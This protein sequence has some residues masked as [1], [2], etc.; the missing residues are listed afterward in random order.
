MGH[1]SYCESCHNDLL[2]EVHK[3]EKEFEYYGTKRN[4]ELLQ[5]KSNEGY[6]FFVQDLETKPKRQAVMHVEIDYKKI[7]LSEYLSQINEMLKSSK[8]REILKRTQH[9]IELINLEE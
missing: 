7:A 3:V 9:S 1:F 6:R 4:T 8:W 5:S 2:L